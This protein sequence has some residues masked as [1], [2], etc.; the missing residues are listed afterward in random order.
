MNYTGGEVMEQWRFTRMS[1]ETFRCFGIP[2][3]QGRGFTPEEDLPNGPAV[4]VISQD[5]WQ[6]A[7]RERSA[8]PRQDY[9]AE[10][11]TAHCGRNRRV[12]L[13]DMREYGPLG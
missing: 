9:L 10:W 13:S 12:T 2:I 5:L 8:D 4:A 1:A 11:R 3:L 7:I 6:T